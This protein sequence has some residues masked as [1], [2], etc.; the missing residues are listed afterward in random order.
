M[1][2]QNRASAKTGSGGPIS[3]QEANALR[4]DR[5]RKLAEETID[6][7]KDPYFIKNH[8]GT[9]ECRLCL[10]VHQTDGSYL[11]HTQ[12]KKHQMNLAKRMFRDNKTS[13]ITPQPKLKISSKKVIKIGKPGYRVIKQ[14]DPDTEQKSLLFE[15]DYTEI[16]PSFIPKHRIMSAFEQ[17]L[18]A[19]DK[20]YQYILFAA[21]PYETIAFKIPN[22]ELDRSAGKFFY[23]WNSDKKVYTLQLYFKN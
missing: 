11:A 18:E 9:Y 19:P 17:K 6:L 16:I 21:E 12:G 8:L 1:D 5:L 13:V 23:N 10:T 7:S 4:R 22:M 14:M 15:V 3:H 2:F 20:N